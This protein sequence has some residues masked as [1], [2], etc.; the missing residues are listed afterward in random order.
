[1]SLCPGPTETN[2]QAVAGTTRRN[3]LEKM[4]PAEEVVEE[5]LAALEKGKGN[6]VAG[7]PNKLMVLG[8]RLVPR[9][10]ITKMAGQ[11]FRQ[12]VK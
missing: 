3:S 1:M 6:V 12:Y 4:Q 11:R 8:E 9:K 7:T 2:F 10:T 5:C